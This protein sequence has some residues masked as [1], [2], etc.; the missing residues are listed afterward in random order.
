MNTPTPKPRDKDLMAGARLLMRALESDTLHALSE[1]F[2][3]SPSDDG[4][5]LHIKGV[6]DV[7]GQWV[8][9]IPDLPVRFRDE[10]EAEA[11][12]LSKAKTLLAGLGPHLMAK[13]K[14]VP[15]IPGGPA[16]NANPPAA[17]PGAARR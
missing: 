11:W 4:S 10:A 1:F 15:P 9:P 12:S 2:D 8:Y 16:A 6:G 5:H 7:G 3:F 14:K 13:G 17:A